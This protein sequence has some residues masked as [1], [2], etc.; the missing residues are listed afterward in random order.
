MAIIMVK[1]FFSVYAMLLVLGVMVSQAPMAQW[2][3]LLSLA[4]HMKMRDCGNLL[5]IFQFVD[6]SF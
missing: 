3:V 4:R 1:L 5:R 6:V 2:K